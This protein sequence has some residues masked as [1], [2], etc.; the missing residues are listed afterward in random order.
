[1]FKKS[2]IMLLIFGLTF[3]HISAQ[4]KKYSP[5]N[6]F[7]EAEIYKDDNGATYS[8]LVSVKFRTKTID[9]KKGLTNA[10]LMDIQVPKVRELFVSIE[11]DFGRFS[12]IKEFGDH[13][14]GD[15]AGIDI[16][17]KRSVK[18]KDLSQFFKLKFDK[19]VCIDSIINR[20]RKSNCFSF[21]DGPFTAYYTYQPNDY[22]ATE[23]WSL[24]RIEATK[25]WDITKGSAQVKIGFPD[26]WKF[27]SNPETNLHVE[28]RNGK[29]VY[30]QLSTSGGHGQQTSGVAAALTDNAVGIASIGFNTSLIYVA[31]SPAGIDTA[32]AHGAQIINCSWIDGDWLPLHDVI[33]NALNQGRIVVASI[34]NDQNDVSAL[35]TIPV[36]AYPAAYNFPAIGRQVIAVSATGLSGS[37]EYFPDTPYQPATWNYSPGSNPVTDPTNS[38]VDVSAPGIYIKVLHD[39][40]TTSYTTASGTSLAAPLVSGLLGLIKSIYSGLTPEIAYSILINS[41]DKVG[42]F[43]Y[44]GYGW[45]QRMGYGRVNAY[46]AL[47]YTIEHYGGTFTQN[48]TIPSGDTWNLQPGVTLTFAS[49]ASLVVNGT[50]NAIG[51]SSSGITFNRSGTSGT[52]GGIQFNSGS[53]GNLQYCN[54]SNATTGI[55]LYNSSP[56]I[57][58]STISNNTGVGLYCDYYSSPTLVGNTVKDNQNH[59]VRCNAYSSPTFNDGYSDANVIRSNTYNGVFAAYNSN[60]N[61][62]K[63]YYGQGN[64]VKSNSSQELSA[65][66]NCTVTAQYVWWG[67]Y[68]PLDSEFSLYQSTL[69]RNNPLTSDPYPNRAIVLTPEEKTDQLNGVSLS[70]QDNDLDVALDK[71][72]IKKYDEAIP[73]FLQV[74]KNNSDALIGKYALSKIEECFTQA[75]K[76]DYLD[77]SKREIKPL[78]KEGSETYVLALELEAHQLVNAGSYKNALSNL[79]S[80]LQKYNLN[81]AIEKNTLFTLGAF[82]HLFYGDEVSS[83]TYFEEL[84]R[85]YP[86]DELVNQISIIKGLSGVS[87]SLVQ[88]AQLEPTEETISSQELNNSMV[89]SNYPNPF[90]PTTKISFSLPQKSQIKLKVFDVLGRE[91]QILA[92]GIYEAGKHEVEFNASSLSS[93]VYFYN[94]SDGANSITKK[95]LLMK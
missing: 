33:Y 54:I 9:L 1:M 60:P 16:I 4:L 36:C 62:N 23:Q 37:T 8:T 89:I 77:Y 10:A 2:F 81:E 43:S 50:L 91:I 92:E 5:Q 11:K 56:L 80:I 40:L 79:L 86:N 61:L 18:L 38:F 65:N 75:G 3:T 78:V 95:M 32:V 22:S 29:V 72:K 41:T 42:Q 63:G 46:K 90:N 31:G 19:V 66:Y 71:Q 14:Y 12:I 64:S 84:K 73:L 7:S 44:D 87:N 49:G 51:N 25:A 39:S 27:Y 6:M 30:N 69:N 35:G 70:I 34:G 59:G 94:L 82:Y 20:L 88:N 28:L 68:P 47:K 52:W 85:K 93:G 53:S 83:D 17:S 74:F 67:N 24:P 45:N 13:E 21:V 76:K 57:K 55:Y 26:G 48:V 15:T 58:Y